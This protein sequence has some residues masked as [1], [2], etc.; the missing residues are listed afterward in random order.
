MRFKANILDWCLL[1]LNKERKIK[2]TKKELIK[3]IANINLNSKFVVTDEYIDGFNDAISA[4][5]KKLK[6]ISINEDIVRCKDCRYYS[7][8]YKLCGCRTDKY[9][10]Y[11]NDDDFCSFGERE[12][13]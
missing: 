8:M 5:I 10:V 4:V 9:N 7:R 6:T 12:K 2:M 3:Q 11:L 13:N 1:L